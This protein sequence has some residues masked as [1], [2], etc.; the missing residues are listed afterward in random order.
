MR[1]MTLMAVGLTLVSAC[2]SPTTALTPA[3]CPAWRSVDYSELP[4]HLND[5]PLDPLLEGIWRNWADAE[6]GVSWETAK[7]GAAVHF[8]TSPGAL[9]T[10]PTEREVV[11]RRSLNGWEIYARSGTAPGWRKQEWTEWRRIRLTPQ[12]D[13]KL[14]AI[15]ADPCLWVAPRFLDQQVRLVN[16]RGDARPDGPSTAYDLM[17]E[18]RR[19]GGWHFSWS[20]GPQ[21]Q[22]RSLLLS[23]AFGLPESDGD[24]IGP[25]GW[26]NW[27]TES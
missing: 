25:D 20:V 17:Q 16:R 7:P 3:Q 2:H 14:T 6:S 22:L 11:G 10:D 1:S 27:P 15:L 5:D 12:G 19:W 24:E 23:E 26:F 18:N 4:T 21:G 8:K 13:R 9:T